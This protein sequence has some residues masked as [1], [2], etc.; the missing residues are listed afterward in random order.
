MTDIAVIDCATGDVVVRPMT[1]E[2]QAA[3]ASIVDTPPP[4]TLDERLA[5]IEQVLEI[6]P[7]EETR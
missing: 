6:T 3:H 5:I 2:E 4:P 7:P 1:N